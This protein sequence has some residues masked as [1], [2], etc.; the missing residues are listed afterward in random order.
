MSI[1]YLVKGHLPIL[2]I[3]R[4]MQHSELSFLCNIPELLILKNTLPFN[5]I[6]VQLELNYGFSKFSYLF[7][8]EKG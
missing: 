3:D 6:S 5:D 4:V 7:V 8:P 2:G 1:R